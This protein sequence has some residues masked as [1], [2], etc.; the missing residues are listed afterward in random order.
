MRAVP[1]LTVTIALLSAPTACPQ[2][3]EP[4]AE[5]ILVVEGETQ[6]SVPAEAGVVEL[7]EAEEAAS[8][9]GGPWDTR[10]RMTGD[11][12]GLR[13]GLAE[14][15]FTFDGY[16]TQFWQ[17]V[18]SGGQNHDGRYG[19][20]L[21]YL[22]NVDGGKA[23]LPQGF[24]INLHGETRLGESVNDI[25][26]LIAPSNIAMNFPE[27][28]GNLTALTGVK[29]TQ[30]LSETLVVYAGKLNTLDEYPLKFS[31]GLGLARPGIGGFMNTSLVF[32]PIAAR[33][34]P[35]SAAGVGFAL[36]EEGEPVL[37]LTL[38]DPEERATI[39]LEDLYE[40]GVV[41]ATDLVL[42]AKI[43][44]LPGVY[45]YGGTYSTATY[46]SVDPAAYLLVPGAGIVAA[47]EEHSWSLYA[48]F[49]QALWVDPCDE[50]RSWGLFGQFGVSD[51]NPNPVRFVANAGLAGRVPGRK[52][53][54]FGA[55]FFYM[56]LSDSF[57]SLLAPLSRS[58]TSMASNSSITSR[59][60]PGAASPRTCRSPIP[61]LRRSA[62]SSFPASGWN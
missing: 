30:A 38:F 61:A 37:A 11:W 25:D 5:E 31:Q 17:A 1:W 42:K 44:G 49:F 43:L 2:E 7:C 34:I 4:L 59:S 26:G 10:S 24:F 47:E 9:Y 27:S 55:G 40:R 45:N 19:A 51:G 33:T 36:L 54:V 53:D 14:N 62:R 13:D 46:R 57:K 35:Y 3:P 28:E 41:V 58:R 21:D 52:L 12:L 32:N 50:T 22:F 29:F 8:I 15:G 48:N 23:G 39:G 20:K 18:T 56:G 6:E 16:G 60:P